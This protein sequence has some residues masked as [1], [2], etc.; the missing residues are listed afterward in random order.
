MF[1]HLENYFMDCVRIKD[2]AKEIGY[3]ITVEEA[4]TIWE[5]HSEDYCAG[6]LI[7][8]DDESIKKIIDDHMPIH[9]KICPH[10]KKPMEKP[11]DE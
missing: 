9:R 3:N 8:R 11:K 5:E 2:L 7:L 1:D 6:W 10:C 4:C